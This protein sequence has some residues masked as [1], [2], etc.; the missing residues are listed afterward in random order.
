LGDVAFDVD[1]QSV[2]FSK[3]LGYK[4]M[5]F[6]GVPNFIYTFGYT[7]ASWTLKADLTAGYASRLFAYMDKHGLASA[8]PVGGPGIETRPFLDFSS[9][10]VQRAAG[11]MPKQG[12]K[13]PWRLYQ[14]YLLDLLTLRYRRIADGTLR[15]T[16]S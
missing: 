10:Y 3:T 5:M 13:A 15:F 14:N 6:S 2:D 11:F 16:R 4:G 7:N 1:G 12:S 8:T 9:G